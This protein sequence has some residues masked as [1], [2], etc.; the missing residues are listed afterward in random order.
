ML[1]RGNGLWRQGNN[2]R[3]TIIS[4]VVADDVNLDSLSDCLNLEDGVYC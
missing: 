2:T 1:C 4:L 3:R